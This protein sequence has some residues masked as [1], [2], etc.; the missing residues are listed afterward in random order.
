MFSREYSFL[1]TG[2][3]LY[4]TGFVD[5]Y[6]REYVCLAKYLIFELGFSKKECENFLYNKT[7]QNNIY[8]EKKIEESISEA[9]KYGALISDSEVL[10]N[11]NDLEYLRIIDDVKLRKLFYVILVLSKVNNDGFCNYTPK[12]INQIAKTRFNSKKIL[13]ELNKI[14][15]MFPEITRYT[16]H[17]GKTSWNIKKLPPLNS[18]FGITLKIDVF[19]MMKYFPNLCKK[20][21]NIFEKKEK[22]RQE[23]CSICSREND[24]EKKRRWKNKYGKKN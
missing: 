12:E 13:Y 20:C 14:S 3:K 15:A 8:I 10:L 22:S 9:N 17:V 7:S 24:L 4:K 16:N 11:G 2:E 1:S 21:K 23:F 6:K 18:D 19:D 5:G